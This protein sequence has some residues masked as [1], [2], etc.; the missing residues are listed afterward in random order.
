LKQIA[1]IDAAPLDAVGRLAADSPQLR[2]NHNFHASAA[3][4]CNR[5]PDST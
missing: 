1:L 4:P 2:K 3:E 5:L